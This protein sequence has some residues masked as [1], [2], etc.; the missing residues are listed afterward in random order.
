MATPME[1]RYYRF[2]RASEI[3][4]SILHAPPASMLK[5]ADDAGCL[6]EFEFL[7]EEVRQWLDDDTYY[8]D[9]AWNMEAG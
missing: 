4:T 5:K 6:F 9:L 7:C 1:D 3:I 8:D 2:K